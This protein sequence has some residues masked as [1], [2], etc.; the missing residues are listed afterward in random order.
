MK[1][2]L[3]ASL[4]II[5][6]G[7]P[8]PVVRMPDRPPMHAPELVGVWHKARKGDTIKSLSRRCGISAQD[9][10]ELNGLDDHTKLK[11]GQ[12]IFLYGIDRLIC[13]RVKRTPTPPRPPAS[14]WTW[15]VKKGRITSRFGAQRGKRRRHRGVD[16]AAQT[17]TKI[18]A[19]RAGTVIFSG[20]QDGYG[21]VI[22]IEHP[23]EFV[24]VY[25]HNSKNIAEE[26]DEVAKGQ[27]IGEVGNTGRSTGPHLHFEMRYRG[28]PVD[29]MKRNR[30]PAGEYRR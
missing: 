4:M 28:T 1:R 22:I 20:T 23:G 27:V 10:R 24:T 5:L 25:A 30:L 13:E 11:A 12:P 15:P 9:I 14:K 17:G 21:R 19:A 2:A 16:I 7:C 29:P 6:T 18:V 26:G 8:D 3:A